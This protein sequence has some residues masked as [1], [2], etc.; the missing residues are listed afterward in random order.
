MRTMATSAPTTAGIPRL[1]SPT[2][3]AY[4]TQSILFRRES[5]MKLKE[6]CWI[7]VYFSL[8]VSPQNMKVGVGAKIR[9]K[10]VI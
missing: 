2:F 8:W 9:M 1:W 5:N 3:R 10:Q 4:A 6:N 7:L